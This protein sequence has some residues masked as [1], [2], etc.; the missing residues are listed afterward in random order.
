MICRK[1]GLKDDRINKL[2]LC[3]ECEEKYFAK[4]NAPKKVFEKCFQ[5]KRS[6]V[7]E[8]VATKQDLIDYFWVAPGVSKLFYNRFSF[9]CWFARNQKK[10]ST[11]KGLIEIRS[12]QC[13]KYNWK[14]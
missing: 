6:Q 10:F 12:I 1:C 13:E 11:V 8:K 3:K 4:K 5:Y 9:G 7:K 2:G 14:I